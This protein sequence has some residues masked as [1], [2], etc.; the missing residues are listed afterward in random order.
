[1]VRC[2][3]LAKRPATH[4]NAQSIVKLP[5]GANAVLRV[6]VV[7]KHGQWNLNC[8]A[9]NIV[10]RMTRPKVAT[11]VLV[12]LIVNFQNGPIVRNHVVP[13]FALKL[14]MCMQTLLENNVQQK[15]P[16]T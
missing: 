12:P 4:K 2:A 8:M 7:F 3:A 6:V 5:T 10:G 16:C 15:N 13:A 9:A 11:L 1:M 14:L